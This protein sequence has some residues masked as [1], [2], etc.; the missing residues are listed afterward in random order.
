MREIKFRGICIDEN[1]ICIGKMVFGFLLKIEENCYIVEVLGED[2]FIWNGVN[3]KTVGQCTGL[4]DKNGAEIYEG[5]I[6]RFDEELSVVRYDEDA[7]RFVLDDYGIRGCLMEY[8]WDEG[9]GGFGIVNTNG[10][11]DFN[12]IS[13]I[14]IIGN[15]YVNPELLEGRK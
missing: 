4:K 3:P 6:V 12:D 13:E 14:E 11:D 8:G 9:A 15:I 5:D 7:A 1:T 2:S 10:F